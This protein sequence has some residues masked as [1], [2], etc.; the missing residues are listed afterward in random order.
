MMKTEGNS[1]NAFENI[2][3]S[4]SK[5]LEPQ[6]TSCPGQPLLFKNKLETIA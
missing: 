3:I 1:P 5:H 2:Y 6:S 4:T